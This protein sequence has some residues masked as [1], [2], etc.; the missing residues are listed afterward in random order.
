MPWK[1]SFHLCL[2][3]SLKAQCRAPVS[4]AFFLLQP[5][6]DCLAPTAVLLT[7]GL[8]SVCPWKVITW[9][10]GRDHVLT[11][12]LPSSK[13]LAL[14]AQETWPRWADVVGP[15]RCPENGNDPSWYQPENFGSYSWIF[16][17]SPSN[18]VIQEFFMPR[19]TCSHCSWPLL[20]SG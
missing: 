18:A 7:V 19:Y 12:C 3:K 2:L 16:L 9:T 20:T 17:N 13:D 1:F 4:M 8:T 6:N 14:V 5:R 11:P 15:D 10:E